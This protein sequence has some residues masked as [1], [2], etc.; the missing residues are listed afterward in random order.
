MDFVEPKQVTEGMRQALARMYGDAFMR[1]YLQN[2]V[3]VAKSNALTTM[4]LGKYEEA[5]DFLS[6]SKALEQL[7]AKGKE[8][9]VHFEQLKKTKDPLKGFNIS[10]VRL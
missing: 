7:L 3:S 5:R 1:E 9:F 2:A 8:H 10:E 6:R 4:G